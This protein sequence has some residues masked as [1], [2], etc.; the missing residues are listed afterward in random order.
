MP[1]LGRPTRRGAWSDLKSTLPGGG[2]DRLTRAGGQGITW[3]LVAA[4]LSKDCSEIGHSA[5][6][7]DSFRQRMCKAPTMGFLS[8]H[9]RDVRVF[10]LISVLRC[11]RTTLVH[12]GLWEVG[13][14]NLLCPPLCQSDER[15]PLS[16]SPHF[17]SLF[18]STAFRLSS[19]HMGVTG[20]RVETG[21]HGNIYRTVCSG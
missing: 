18:S 20:F 15:T 21:E 3:Q 10:Y 6:V 12:R 7:L 13:C 11:E 4:P 19:S 5:E 16:C 14:N 8:A 9:S 2:V 1:R 17:P